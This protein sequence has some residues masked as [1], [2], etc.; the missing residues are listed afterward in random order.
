MSLAS[1]TARMFCSVVETLVTGVEDVTTPAI[2]HNTKGATKTLTPVTKMS[3]F[4][5]T[6]DGATS[7]IDLTALVGANG[8]VNGT[9]L[10][11][12]WFHVK[13]TSGNANPITV[14]EGASNGYALAGAA[15]SIILNANQE[16]GFI[17]NDTTPDVASGDRIIDIAGTTGQSIEVEVI[18]G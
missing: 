13:A 12:Q 11:V 8:A 14:K 4:T 17:G 6:L 1:A 16:F 7:T 15:W 3:V 18:L 9:G 2:T 10:K 5:L